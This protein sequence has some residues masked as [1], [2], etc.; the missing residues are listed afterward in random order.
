VENKTTINIT[1]CILSILF[2]FVVTI[3]I[4]S[5]IV[6]LENNLMVSNIQKEEF[7][8]TIIYFHYKK[9]LFFVILL[10]L[11]IYFFWAK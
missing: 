3:L 8:N 10:S 6:I 5:Y 1:K 2:A 11:V 4:K 7:V 9:Y